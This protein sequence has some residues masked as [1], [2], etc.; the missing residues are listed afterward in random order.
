MYDL[1]LQKGPRQPDDSQTLKNHVGFALTI[2]E[3][4]GKISR[5]GKGGIRDPYFYFSKK[6]AEL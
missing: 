4:E 6:S 2:L 3:R 5:A 1:F